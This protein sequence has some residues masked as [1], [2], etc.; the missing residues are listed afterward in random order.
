M[1]KK[2][3]IKI[4]DKIREFSEY[5][6]EY[7]KDMNCGKKKYPKCSKQFDLYL[8]IL[9]SII[10]FNKPDKGGFVHIPSKYL[11]KLFK[12]DKMANNVLIAAKEK[13]ITSD[14][15]YNADAGISTGY[16]ISDGMKYCSIKKLIKPKT[17]S[18]MT[19][20]PTEP[21]DIAVKINEK[22]DNLIKTLRRKFNTSY[23]H[24]RIEMIDKNPM[25]EQT[26]KCCKESIP[27]YLF[28][29]TKD[30]TLYSKC[31]LCFELEKVGLPIHALNED[32][33]TEEEA[34]REMCKKLVEWMKWKN[35]RLRFKTPNPLHKNN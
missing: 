35:S 31:Q 25:D 15:H 14:G 22:R 12:S 24:K 28:T 20:E 9:V 27:N 23:Y 29:V 1:N 8:R 6:L 5:E 19:T 34:T 13:L 26:C 18:I 3:R 16:K 21:D 7:L 4:P 30:R 17:D 2:I 10:E 33:F 11:G 32:G